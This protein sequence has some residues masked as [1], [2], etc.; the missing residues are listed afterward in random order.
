MNA[1]ERRHAQKDK[2]VFGL[3]TS[4]NASRHSSAKPMIFEIKALGFEEVELSFNLTSQMV[5]DIEKLVKKNQI[6]VASLHNFCPIP[7]DL[8]R[9]IALPDC[10]SMASCNKEE[11]LASIKQ[12]KN[13]IDT[14]RKLGA[15]VV[16]L[17]AGRV[18]IPD[19]TKDLINLYNQGHKESREFGAL[20]N[21][22]L[23]ERQESIKLFFNNALRSLEELDRYAKNRG[24]FLGIENRFYYREIPS[25]EEIG[26]ILNKFK[27]SSIFYWHDI[28]HAQVMEN[29]GFFTHKEY[30]NLY[31]KDI[32]GIH[33]HDVIGCSDH[34]PPGQGEF[35]FNQIKPYLKKDV[36]KIM[37]VHQPATTE[38]L[39]TSKNFLRGLLL[40]EKD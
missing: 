39:E 6:R 28:G 36:I 33:L 26:T 7:S 10:Y 20:K 23:K 40:N 15:K 3:S 2:Y 30:F 21:L 37:E 34:K 27:D 35:D 11:R 24:I 9:E 13:S 32:I 19:R 14:A 18:D 31:N 4:W 29:L 17:H 8:K 1:K 12:T 25:Q 22:A 16:V 5:D 38:D